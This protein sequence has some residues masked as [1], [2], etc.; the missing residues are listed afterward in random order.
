MNVGSVSSSSGGSPAQA[1]QRATEG[2]E[3]KKGGRD[4]DGDSDDGG[5]KAVAPP[6][7][8]TNANGQ[9][10]GQIINATA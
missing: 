9:T 2:A 8:R 7:A 4:N 5:V 10:V 6:A 3:V 1:I